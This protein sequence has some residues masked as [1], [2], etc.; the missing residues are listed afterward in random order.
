EGNLAESVACAQTGLH[1]IVIAARARKPHGG[2]CSLRACV[3]GTR[4]RKVRSQ[5]AR[6]RRVQK[7]SALGKANNRTLEARPCRERR[8]V[9]EKPCGLGGAPLQ[10]AQVSVGI[11]RSGA[12]TPAPVHDRADLR[13]QRGDLEIRGHWDGCGGEKSPRQIPVFVSAV[14]VNAEAPP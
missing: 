9:P 12:P 4:L 11:F 2:Q 6:R 13:A 3:A 8:T 14:K 7:E 1:P 10:I 5:F